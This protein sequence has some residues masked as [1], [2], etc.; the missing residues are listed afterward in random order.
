MNYLV[1]QTITV[2]FNKLGLSKSAIFLLL[3]I[4]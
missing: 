4:L 1:E 2:L 3:L